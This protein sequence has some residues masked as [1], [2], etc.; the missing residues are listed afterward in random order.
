VSTNEVADLTETI[1]GR[2][3]Q[4]LSSGVAIVRRPGDASFTSCEIV[5]DAY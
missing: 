5:R 3:H 2:R 4:R 1:A